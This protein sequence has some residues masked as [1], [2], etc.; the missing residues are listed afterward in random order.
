V[1]YVV[2]ILLIA[3]A[4]ISSH[5]E[6]IEE[7]F[8]PRKNELSQ[9]G[10]IENFIIP[11][12]TD[13]AKIRPNPAKTDDKERQFQLDIL[14]R[15]ENVAVRRLNELLK[16]KPA[17]SRGGIKVSEADRKKFIEKRN[18]EILNLRF[19]LDKIK[20]ERNKLINK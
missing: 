8:K 1:K 5:K 7:K 11:S 20:E 2:I 9:Q 13:P 18:Q 19:Y 17:V 12:F 15:N 4:F 16:S 6:E 14:E 10:E 3:G